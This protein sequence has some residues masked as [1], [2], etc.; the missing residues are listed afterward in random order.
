MPQDTAVS[1]L[2]EIIEDTLGSTTD[3]ET[4]VSALRDLQSALGTGIGDVS[5]NGVITIR[6]ANARGAAYSIGTSTTLYA[7]FVLLLA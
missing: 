4:V 1:V 7:R 5:S 3:A 6:S 2:T